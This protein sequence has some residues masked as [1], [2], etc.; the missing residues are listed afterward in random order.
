MWFGFVWAPL[1]ANP[2]QSA[3][4]IT[5]IKYV[6]F[7]SVSSGLIG[8]LW[9]GGTPKGLNQTVRFSEKDLIAKKIIQLKM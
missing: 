2:S 1:P 4:S 3:K 7:N 6:Q 9:V 8:I 5:V